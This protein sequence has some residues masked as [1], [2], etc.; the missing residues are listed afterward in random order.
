MRDREVLYIPDLHPVY[1]YPLAQHLQVV[2]FVLHL[3]EAL[4]DGVIPVPEGVILIKQTTKIYLTIQQAALA[5][6]IA[7]G[8]PSQLRHCLHPLPALPALPPLPLLPI[9]NKN[10]ATIQIVRIQLINH[11][12]T[13]LPIKQRLALIQQYILNLASLELRVDRIE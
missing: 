2:Y 5:I 9:N 3:I 7:I 13:F 8:R 4:Q 12:L 1:L 6:A 10:S 11:L